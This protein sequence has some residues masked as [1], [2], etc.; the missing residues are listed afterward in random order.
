MFQMV[1]MET[2]DRVP[3]SEQIVIQLLTVFLRSTN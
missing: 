1:S 2:D 3:K